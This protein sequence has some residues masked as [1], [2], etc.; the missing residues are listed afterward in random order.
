MESRP[1]T[2]FTV[3]TGA[4]R[5]I[6]GVV[7]APAGLSPGID[8]VAALAEA[9]GRMGLAALVPPVAEPGQGGADLVWK[10]N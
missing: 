9:I 7:A 6:A 10:E 2:A 8:P 3:T 5:R 1:G 4:A